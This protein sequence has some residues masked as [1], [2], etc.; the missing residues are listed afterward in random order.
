MNATTKCNLPIV[1]RWMVSED[2]DA[3]LRIEEDALRPR[4]TQP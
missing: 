1:L 3:V 4:N 2:L